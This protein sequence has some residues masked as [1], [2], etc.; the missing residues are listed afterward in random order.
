M[1]YY[2]FK[3]TESKE[4]AKQIEA[5]P[6]YNSNMELSVEVGVVA[7]GGRRNHAETPTGSAIIQSLHELARILHKK[8]GESNVPVTEDIKI[9]L[10]SARI[11]FVVIGP[12]DT[13]KKQRGR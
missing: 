9:I 3:F 11:G 6:E 4:A 2:L 10:E 8:E 7:L 5:L 13:N 1:I 12:L